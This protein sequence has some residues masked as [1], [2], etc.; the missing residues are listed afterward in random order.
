MRIIW[1]IP[2]ILIGILVIACGSSDSSEPTES[3]LRETAGEFSELL[4][5]EK[6]MDAYRFYTP[7]FQE[8]CPAGEFAMYTGMGMMIF[9][10]LMGIDEDEKLG[11][12]ITGV[13]VDGLNGSVTAD[14][15]YKGEPLDFG[16][17]DDDEWLGEEWTFINGQWKY[18]SEECPSF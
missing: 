8:T 9:K 3:G 6:W 15:L 11:W 2:L 18:V 16:D 17:S 13:T 7:E 14:V 1:A 10:G 12:R 4:A 5:N